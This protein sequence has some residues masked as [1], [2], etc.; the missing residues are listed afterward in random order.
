MLHANDG[1][2]TP[3][4][5]D[6]LSMNIKEYERPPETPGWGELFADCGEADYFSSREWYTLFLDTVVARSDGN[7]SFLTAED[8]RGS[9]V[10]VLPI[11]RRPRSGVLGSGRLD[12]LAN[13]YSCLYQPLLCGDRGRAEHG[14]ESLVRHLAAERARWSII[15]LRPL[16]DDAWYVPVFT[17][18]FQHHG[19]VARTYPA[20]GNWYLDAAQMDFEEYFKTRRKKMR[21]TVRSKTN[22][23]L[24]EH[25]FD[26]RIVDGGED[27]DDVIDA[28]NTV[29]DTSWKQSEPYPEFIPTFVRSLAQS[30]KLRLGLMTVD[31]RPAAAQLWFVSGGIAHI[32]KLA[33]DPAFASFSVGTI[34]TMKL[35]EHVLDT[36]GVHMVDFLS[37][38][39]DYK[40]Q[41][42]SGRRQ[43]I[44]IEIVNRRSVAGLLIEARHAA[45]RVRRRLRSNGA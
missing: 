22:Q 19:I 39:D 9:P 17:R 6:F 14:L 23:L 25:A 1:V 31:G 7:A 26:M 44:G 27:L 21:S 4:T 45:S 5:G 29:Y 37:G 38:D 13:Y 12:S 11:W 20:F 32:F 28:Y 30:G 3:N 34:L 24:K 16:P 35:M 40:K 33:Y 18:A 15:D 43:R 41:W 8:E 42:M 36:D 10:A 2:A